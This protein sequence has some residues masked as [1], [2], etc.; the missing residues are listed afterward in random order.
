MDEMADCVLA[1]GPRLAAS[2]GRRSVRSFAPQSPMACQEKKDSNSERA[3]AERKDTEQWHQQAKHSHTQTENKKKKI[4]ITHK[5]NVCFVVVRCESAE[6]RLG[7]QQTATLTLTIRPQP[8][9]RTHVAFVVD[10]V[11]AVAG[12][13]D[14]QQAR[15]HIPTSR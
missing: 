10:A 11:R 3:R 1:T 9:P 4:T 13:V 15:L 14:Q 5:S 6:E 12:I 7:E 2:R 8:E